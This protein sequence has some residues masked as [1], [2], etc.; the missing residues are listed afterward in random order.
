MQNYSKILLI[1]ILGSFIAFY[2][3]DTFFSSPSEPELAS[4]LATKNN[5]FP[6]KKLPKNNRIDLAWKQ[7]FERTKDLS[8]GTVPRERLKSALKVAKEKRSSI[9]PL[10]K[11][12]GVNGITGITGINWSERGPNNIG[13][14]TRAI[15]Y[16]PNDV[17]GTKVWAGSVSGGLWYN[18]DITDANS[19]WEKVDD[20]W[21]NL[22]VTC[23]AYDPNDTDIFYVGTGEG[24]TSNGSSSAR[25]EG[26]WKSTDGGTTWA[27][28][29]ATAG[30]YWVN[31]IVVRNESGSSVIYSGNA[32]EVHLS[33]F[34]S[35]LPDQGLYRSTDGGDNFSQVLPI[36]SG[37]PYSV[38]DIE[39]GA[40]NRIYVGTEMNS[41][42]DGEGT[43]LYSDDGTT[44]IVNTNYSGIANVG[45]VE[46][47]CAPSDANIVYAL[48]EANSVLE[49]VG[50]SDDKGVTWSDM[51]EPDDLDTG[52]PSTD[53][54]REQAWYDLILAVDPNDATKVYAG[55]ID[56]FRGS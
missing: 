46:L 31:D 20:F 52:I 5:S 55:G 40:D 51:D 30:Y 26:I 43:I 15:M 19:S 45:R 48:I 42:L 13:G 2:V 29:A 56:L 24:F 9:S 1:L 10:Q 23:I 53:F 6:F 25:G 16:D 50:Y 32:R 35:G 28:L 11:S 47:A 34:Y 54:S 14:R 22:A 39:I 18:D 8:L 27:Q 33:S 44:W 38:A 37:R 17:S 4:A 7:E 41:A 36:I 49:R 3:F 12:M 21:D